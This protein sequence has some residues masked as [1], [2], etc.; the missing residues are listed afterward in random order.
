[1]TWLSSS[2]RSVSRLCALVVACG[3]ASLA[4]ARTDLPI[5]Y[6][7]VTPIGYVTPFGGAGGGSG[8]GGALPAGGP[9]PTLVPATPPVP[10]LPAAT[11]RPTQDTS[12]APTQDPTRPSVLLR[13]SAEEYTVQRGDSL[14][15]ISERYGVTR[16]EIAEANG[17]LVTDTL[18]ANQVLLIP[19]PRVQN[20]GPDLKLIPD[21]ELV[22]GPGTVGFNLQGFIE[23]QHGYLATY[24]EDVPGEL[25][26]G[27][28][29]V[30]PLS[31]S[32]I[33]RIVSQRYSV[34]PRLLLAVLEYQSGWVTHPRPSDSTLVYPL[35]QVEVGRE[36]LFR[37]LDWAATQ[38]NFGYYAWRV[39]ALVSW[40]F[41]DRALRLTALGL[42]AGTVGVQHLF[43]Q[44]LDVEHWTRAVS[45][46]GFILTY[47]AMFG[48][49][50]ALALDPLI[51][52]NLTQPE[53]VL[54][55]EPGRVWAFTSGPHG[56]WK[57]GSAWAALDFAPPAEAVGCLPSEEWVAAAAPGLV[58]RSDYGAVLQDL[59]SDG[60]EGTGWVLFYMHVKQRD[61]VPVGTYLNVGDRLGHPSCEGGFANGTHVHFA[62]KYNGEWISADSSIPFLLDG[63][64]SGGLGKEYDGTLSKDGVA[65]EACNCRD[66]VNEI[67]R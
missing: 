25:L 14:G 60:Y 22:Y 49:P 62:R 19:V 50:F 6:A 8:D 17:I 52:P 16:A 57:S 2:R 24:I 65:I 36:G 12:F 48:N 11:P 40:S 66:A 33:V 45:T 43:A 34:N 28:V 21:S 47:W 51:P 61:R 23:S 10:G 3:L 41:G 29:E 67:S 54:P 37:Q 31:G 39:G 18:F 5:N 35:R 20:Y 44:L 9:T 26:D 15:L 4:C 53:L 59:D 55:F 56:A 32:E 7:N 27:L 30:T 1:M 38:L 42:N 58:V 13:Q 63:W 46:Q 64:V